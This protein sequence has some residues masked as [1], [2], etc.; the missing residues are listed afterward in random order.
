MSKNKGQSM[1]VDIKKIEYYNI[2]VDSY[3]G[4]ASKLLSGFADVGISWLAFK[5]VALEDMRTRFTLFPNDS[6]KMSNGAIKAGQNL[7]G[8][9]LAILIKSAIDE[10]GDLAIIYEKL[11][12]VDINVHESCGIAD[13]KGGY[14]VILYLKHEDCEEALAALDK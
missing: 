7:D 1:S 14:G 9:Y 6:S 5:A 11:A 12:Q 4:E 3:I 10:P 2:I 8:P 13:I